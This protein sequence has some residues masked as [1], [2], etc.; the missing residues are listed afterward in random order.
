MAVMQIKGMEEYTK[1]IKDNIIIFLFK[2]II[3]T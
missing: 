3:N 1:K 2:L